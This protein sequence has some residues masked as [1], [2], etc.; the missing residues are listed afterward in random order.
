MCHKTMLRASGTILFFSPLSHSS[1]DRSPEVL[2]QRIE[3]ATQNHS[4]LGRDL[5][6]TCL[7][8]DEIDGA[9]AVS[10]HVQYWERLGFVSTIICNAG[11]LCLTWWRESC[12]HIISCPTSFSDMAFFFSRED[13]YEIKPALAVSTSSQLTMIHSGTFCI[14]RKVTKFPCFGGLVFRAQFQHFLSAFLRSFFAMQLALVSMITITPTLS[15]SVFSLQRTRHFRTCGELWRTRGE[16]WLYFEMQRQLDLWSR[17][18]REAPKMSVACVQGPVDRLQY[19]STPVRLNGHCRVIFPSIFKPNISLERSCPDVNERGLF[20]WIGP[21]TAE[22][23]PF[24]VCRRIDFAIGRR[25]RP[26]YN[27]L[28]L[29]KVQDKRTALEAL[30]LTKNETKYSVLFIFQLGKAKEN[31][32]LFT[33][34]LKNISS[35][36]I[37]K[38]SSPTT[39]VAHDK[40]RFSKEWW[41]GSPETTSLFNSNT[42]RSAP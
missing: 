35:K 32:K 26:L 25:R 1:D 29:S 15:L 36:C 17:R 20:L 19:L 8:I 10:Y 6:P 27:S 4:V 30:T 9:Q 14:Q 40:T 34:C 12:S 39:H 28:T 13:K 37:S 5:R 33:C 2:Q 7:V 21:E 23:R 24:E 22:R 3:T 16:L 38:Q 31:A 11:V 18:S 42:K 41:P